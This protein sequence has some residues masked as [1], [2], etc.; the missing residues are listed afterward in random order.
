MNTPFMNERKPD[1]WSLVAGRFKGTDKTYFYLIRGGLLCDPPLTLE[2]QRTMA[3]TRIRLRSRM[4]LCILERILGKR[5]CGSLVGIC[6]R[7]AIS[8]F[9]WVMNFGI[10]P[11]VIR[12]MTL[13]V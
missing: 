11:Q 4:F 1:G 9:L 6:L 13:F 12:G 5:P 8:G 10:R 7:S 2:R 3:F